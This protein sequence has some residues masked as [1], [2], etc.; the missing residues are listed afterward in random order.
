MYKRQYSYMALVP[1]IQPPIMRALT[2]KKERE[3][4]MK[5]L[6]PVKKIEKIIFPIVV[7]AFVALLVPSAGALVGCLM[8]GRCV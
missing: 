7:T 3:I 2:T 6:R 5:Q 1:V 8:L 4:E